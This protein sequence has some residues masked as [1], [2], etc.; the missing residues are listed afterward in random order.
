MVY[1]QLLETCT[2]LVDEKTLRELKTRPYT[3]M[4]GSVVAQTQP[5]ILTHEFSKMRYL[6]D[7][8][9]V[10]IATKQ[11]LAESYYRLT[12]FVLE[13]T[14]RSAIVSE[15]AFTSWI[16]GTHSPESGATFKISSYRV[17][18]PVCKMAR[19]FSTS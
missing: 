12:T 11:E 3:P 2:W 15:A 19:E 6:A 18:T 1:E 10:G 4:H 9:C 14:P 13:A 8:N 16:H 5:Y 17:R 7:K